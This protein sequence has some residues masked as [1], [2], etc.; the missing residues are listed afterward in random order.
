MP[1]Q[2]LQSL[3]TPP[4][5]STATAPSRALVVLAVAVLVGAVVGLGLWDP[6][7]VD[8]RAHINRVAKQAVRSIQ[9]DVTADLSSEVMGVVRLAK[10]IALK[11]SPSHIA[12]ISDAELYLADHPSYLAI[13]WT[14]ATYRIVWTAEHESG[15]SMLAEMANGRELA[16]EVPSAFTRDQREATVSEPFLLADGQSACRVIVPVRNDQGVLGFLVAVFETDKAFAAILT[17][18]SE[19]GYAVTISQ[20]GRELYRM[21]GSDGSGDFAQTAQ[22]KLYGS[23][24]DIRLW[25]EAGLLQEVGSKVPEV[26]FVIGTLLGISLV[27]TVYFARTAIQRSRELQVAHDELEIRVEQRTSQVHQLSGRLLQLQDEERRHIARELHD[28][29]AQVLAGV[30]IW[31]DKCRSLAGR[32]NVHVEADHSLKEAIEE[33]AKLVE[34]ATS[35][36]RTMSYLLHPPMLDDLGLVEVV[37]WFASGFSKRSGIAV[38]LDLEPALGRLSRELELTLF[39]IVQ[40]GLTNVHRHSGSAKAGITLHKRHDRLTLAIADQGRGFAAPS[41]GGNLEP[42]V[43]LGVGIRG[44]EERVRQMGGTF[45]IRSNPGAGTIVRAEFP[46]GPQAQPE[47]SHSEE[48]RHSAAN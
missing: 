34:Q 46:V 7:R 33:S 40:E 6:L 24:W 22:V 9:A 45:S 47:S 36:A 38:E 28:G 4:A 10:S 17:D 41:H 44:M 3:A 5:R 26:I 13:Y 18:H 23:V 27:L 15:E 42:L 2:A 25:P 43:S 31:L 39:R 37:R 29:I 35:E 11:D 20:S 32:R 16:G 48:L 19:L 12:A 14:D 8:E 21:H 30:A 1:N